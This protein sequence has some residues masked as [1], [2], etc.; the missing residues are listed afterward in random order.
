MW[1]V[2]GFIIGVIWLMSIVFGLRKAIA[3]DYSDRGDRVFMLGV[4]TIF[5]FAP[6]VFAPLLCIW[7]NIEWITKTKTGNPS[8]VR[9]FFN[10]A[11]AHDFKI[12]RAYTEIA[13]RRDEIAE[14]IRRGDFNDDIT[15]KNNMQQLL[16]SLRNESREIRSMAYK[17]G[18]IDTD[19][20]IR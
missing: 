19:G 12:G 7:F 9:L 17:P 14:Q 13:A 2:F 8:R 6:L 3:L 16:D 15:L 4:S 5:V 20:Y 10:P 11:E 1:W 18:R